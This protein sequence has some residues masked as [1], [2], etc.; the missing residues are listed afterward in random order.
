MYLTY[1]DVRT[2]CAAQRQLR[3]NTEKLEELYVW[4]AG[5]AR[6]FDFVKL[7]MLDPGV[8]LSANKSSDS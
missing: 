1:I 5:V 7:Q 4:F 6:R 3:S 8:P 2:T